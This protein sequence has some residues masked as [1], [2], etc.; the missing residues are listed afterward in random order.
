[1]E[2]CSQLNV[3]NYECLLITGKKF[4]PSYLLI[5]FKVQ[6][7]TEYVLKLEFKPKHD[8]EQG[9]SQ[10]VGPA[11]PIEMLFQIFRLNFSWNMSKMHYFSNKFSKIAKRYRGFP[12][13][14]TLN[15]QHWWPEVP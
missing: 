10:R 6:L 9:R 2:Y 4:S 1:M 7:S 8:W 12:P 5:F 14:A 15:L 3:L 13:P 11:P